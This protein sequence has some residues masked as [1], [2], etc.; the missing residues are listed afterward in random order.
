MLVYT[1]SIIC[2]YWRHCMH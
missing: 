2:L 1:Y